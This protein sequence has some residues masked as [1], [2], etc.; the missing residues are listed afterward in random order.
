MLHNKKQSRNS[1][2]SM[3][4]NKRP[5]YVSHFAGN[6]KQENGLK[7]QQIQLEDGPIKLTEADV[8]KDEWENCLVGYFGG[9]FPGKNALQQLVN[10]WKQKVSL[11]F[12]SNGWIIFKFENSEGRDNTLQGG[13][14]MVFGRPLLLKILPEYFTFSYEDL[15]CFPIWVQLKSLPVEAWNS[16]ALSKLCSRIGKP[17]YTDKLTVYKDRVTF[18]RVLIEVDV[19]KPITRVLEVIMPNGDTVHQAVFYE[20]LPL[21]CTHCKT[22]NHSTN[23]CRVL[24][25]FAAARNKGAKFQNATEAVVTKPTTSNQEQSIGP[26]TQTEWRTVDKGKGNSEQ[27]RI[28]GAKH[29]VIQ[30]QINTVE[31]R[32]EPDPSSTNKY[33]L[34]EGLETEENQTQPLVSSADQL[35]NQASGPE[36]VT[37]V[38]QDMDPKIDQGTEQSVRK[39]PGQ[40]K[41][42]H[43]NMP[44]HQRKVQVGEAI[45]NKQASQIASADFRNRLQQPTNLKG[46]SSIVEKK[47]AAQ[48]KSRSITAILAT[49]NS[50]R[51][52]LPSPPNPLAKGEEGSK[53]KVK[54]ATEKNDK[55]TS[56][57]DFCAEMGGDSP[58]PAIK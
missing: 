19:A 31:A 7:L 56:F 11:H 43:R 53:K 23:G 52:Q 39:G 14:Y 34:L 15:S 17:V 32:K 48:P 3:Q 38:S 10:S 21:Y 28:E 33:S 1:Q 54:K 36:T 13:P 57:G 29:S 5:P 50:E 44:K 51:P 12:H 18:A 45:Y 27:I 41:E 6:R 40:A 4:D 46:G 8:S 24:E 9:K 2:K 30:K 26:S 35:L 47:I 58:I 20:N 37:S 16:Y 49:K 25:K 42:Q 55:A 22:V